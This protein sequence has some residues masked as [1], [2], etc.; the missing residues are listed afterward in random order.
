MTHFDSRPLLIYFAVKYGGD[1]H[2][3]I[4]ALELKEDPPMKEVEKVN[5]SLKCKAITLLD[6]DY[7]LRLKQI[8]FPPIVLFYYGDISLLDNPQTLAV[9]GSR[10]ISEYGKYCTE[11]I[12][13]EIAK[14]RV[15]V[16]GLAQGID[17]TAHECAI[18]SGG[19]TIAVLG[20]GIDYCWP[21]DNQK[22]YDEIKKNHLLISEYP[23]RTP[24]NGC[25][26]PMRNRI[27]VGLS[28][29]IYVPQVNT[30]NSGTMISVNLALEMNKDV[31][32]APEAIP[33]QT[34]NN[35]LIGEGAIITIDSETILSELKWR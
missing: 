6:Y 29:G 1:F 10:K 3:I 15:I 5:R 12:V 20:S 8:L 25:N 11:K 35:Q 28:N 24:P 23:G 26:F 18:N 9:V 16:S 19:R 7:P 33:C 30:Y 27:V 4:T 2:K 34:A 22:L 32:V 21:P 14:G 17:A 13:S 31:F